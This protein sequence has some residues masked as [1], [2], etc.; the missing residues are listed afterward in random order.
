MMKRTHMVVGMSLLAVLGLGVLAGCSGKDSPAAPET[1]ESQKKINAE[2]AV[3]ETG[4][5]PAAAPGSIAPGGG[6]AEKPK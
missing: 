2:S 3:K 6:T 5:Q 4:N 1:P